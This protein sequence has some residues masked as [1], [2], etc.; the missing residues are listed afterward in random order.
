MVSAVVGSAVKDRSG[1]LVA[2]IV[3]AQYNPKLTVLLKKRTVDQVLAGA[4]QG[5]KASAPGKA[6][7]TSRVFS[8][9]QVRLVHTAAMSMAVSYKPGGKLIEVLGPAPAPVLRVI[10][11]YL[12][13]SANR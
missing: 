7:V 12:A 2:A 9:S 11:A 8:G 5:A 6:T 3:L 10:A 4:V 1:A 13:A